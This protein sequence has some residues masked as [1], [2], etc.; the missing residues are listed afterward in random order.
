MSRDR[1]STVEG[2]R[3]AQG[4]NSGG[5]WVRQRARLAE[6]VWVTPSEELHHVIVHALAFTA[7]S[8][9]PGGYVAIT[10]GATETVGGRTGTTGIAKFDGRRVQS[11]TGHLGLAQPQ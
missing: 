7:P 1:P 11:E 10:E 4:V 3:W 9:C 5:Q 8:V 2:A 6:T